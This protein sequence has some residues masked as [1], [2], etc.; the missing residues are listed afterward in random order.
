MID[1]LY[2]RKTY[3]EQPEDFRIGAVVSDGMWYTI[4]KWRQIAKV[5]EETLTDWINQNLATGMLV[6]SPCGAHSYRFPKDSVEKWYADNVMPFDQMGDRQ[7]LEFTLPARIW[8]GM[9]EVEGFDDAPR[10]E[11]GVLTFSSSN[12]VANEVMEKLRGIARVREVAPGKYKCYCLD[13][14]YVKA[15]IEEVFANHDAKDISK[16][17]PRSVSKRRE[18]VDLDP[19]FARNLVTFYKNFGKI[20]VRNYQETISIFLPEPEDQEGQVIMW[21]LEAIEKFNDDKPVPFPGYLYVVLNRWPYGLP[22]EHLGDQLADFQRQRAKALKALKKESDREEYSSRELSDQMGIPHS[23]FIALESN[24]K[25]WLSSRKAKTLTWAENNEERGG[26]DLVTGLNPTSSPS[27]VE[28]SHKLSLAAIRA[29][30]STEMYN[31]AL[32]LISQ[33]DLSDINMAA[34]RG[35]SEEYIQSLGAELGMHAEASLQ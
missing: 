4:P 2:T 23:Q 8:S 29:A 25:V 6:Q 19:E 27:D 1:A 24:H 30:N 22:N 32:V 17:T 28:M 5:S 9:T 16:I 10:R 12:A 34:L 21:V 35:I 15:I 26:Q 7:L 33:I 31:D 3:R 18:I 11:V 13:A 20:L 14:P